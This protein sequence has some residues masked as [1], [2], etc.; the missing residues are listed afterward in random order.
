MNKNTQSPFVSTLDEALQLWPKI[1]LSNRCINLTNQKFN[2]LICLYPTKKENSIKRFWVCQCECGNYTMGET[3]SI[4]SGKKK[5]CGC[6]I[7]KNRNNLTG[8]KFDKLLVINLDLEFEKIRKPG[9]HKKWICLCDCGNKCSKYENDL[10]KKNQKIQSCGCIGNSCG[11][12]YI[13]EWLINHNINFK[14]QYTFQ[15][16][17][18]N[19]NYP[20]KFDFA[21][22]DNNN[23]LQY[24]IEYQGIQHFEDRGQ[25]GKQQ[26]EETDKLKFDYCIQ[27]K[28][29]LKYIKYNDNIE[30]KLIE[31]L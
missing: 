6:E 18:S 17:R 5:S 16:L 2:K 12:N 26:R 8:Q 1:N 3:N 22:L 4:I 13:Q 19:K 27:N 25:F 30:E 20:L 14:R 9:T 15:N 23:V 11:E 31:F 28:I 21:I 29:I 7:K 10:L 24:L